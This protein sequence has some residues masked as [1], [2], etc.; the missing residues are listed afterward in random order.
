MYCTYCICSYVQTF[1]F[2]FF[3]NLY[4]EM[5]MHELGRPSLSPSTNPG[6]VHAELIETQNLV[7]ST[8]KISPCRLL[9]DYL[10]EMCLQYEVK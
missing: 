8:C 1:F 4:F 2:F 10:E 9:V 6:L 3:N 5:S 7:C